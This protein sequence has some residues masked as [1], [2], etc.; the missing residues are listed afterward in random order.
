M[1]MPA[2]VCGEVD[3]GDTG[4]EGGRGRAVG[5]QVGGRGDVVDVARDPREVEAV[6]V[7]G[8]EGAGGGGRERGDRDRVAVRVVDGRAGRQ[9][10]VRV[11]GRRRRRG[12]RH[13]RVGGRAVG[14]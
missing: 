14:A 8:V 11:G 2:G 10:R 13:V 7:R 1:R 6:R 9:G 12:R 4:R 5:G 3:V